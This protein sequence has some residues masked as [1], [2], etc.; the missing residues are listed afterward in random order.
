M[1]KKVKAAI[2]GSGN[3][4]TDLMMKII[5][6]GEQY[7]LRSQN[8][9]QKCNSYWETVIDKPA[10][11]RSFLEDLSNAPISKCINRNHNSDILSIQH[12][13]GLPIA[14]IL[15]SSCQSYHWAEQIW[16][17]KIVVAL[18]EWESQINSNN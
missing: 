6:Q 4:G 8:R 16:V 17:K 1:T 2:I 11:V 9:C 12:Y 14:N 3:I 10:A 7:L 18:N 15:C 13:E 5:R